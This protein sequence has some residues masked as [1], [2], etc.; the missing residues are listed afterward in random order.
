MTSTYRRDAIRLI[1]KQC[2]R[3]YTIVREGEA[4]GRRHVHN[5]SGSEEVIQ[6]RRWGIQFECQ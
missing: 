6:E 2:G 3:H 5:V 1:E 4:K